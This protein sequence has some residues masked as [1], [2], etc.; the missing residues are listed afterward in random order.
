MAGSDD[1][2]LCLIADARLDQRPALAREL[3]LSASGRR[4]TDPEL[5]LAAYRRWGVGCLEH[6]L[7]DFSFLLWDEPRGRLFCARDHLG[8]RPLYYART[9]AGF[10]FGSSPDLLHTAGV[11]APELNR[12]R[13]ADYLA[14]GL[15]GISLTSSFFQSV[16]RLPPAHQLC[17]EADETKVA[18]YWNPQE[19][20]ELR[21]SSDAEAADAVMEVLGSAVS[22]RLSSVDN[23]ASMLSGGLDSSLL[24]C[25]T[26][27]LSAGA[28]ARQLTTISAL[29]PEPGDCPDPFYVDLVRRALDSRHLSVSTSDMAKL[30][31]ELRSFSVAA[32][33]PFDASMTMVAA[34]CLKAKSAGFEAVM[35]GVDGDLVAS[36]GDDYL[37]RLL[38]DGRWRTL[39][40][41][42]MAM[43]RIW[44][45]EVNLFGLFRYTLLPGLVPTAFRALRR[46]S[47]PSRIAT[48]LCRDT[49]LSKSFINEV[50]LV[51]RIGEQQRLGPS[52]VPKTMAEAHLRRVT[53][54][55]LT[56]GIERYSRVAD[57]CG[58]SHLSPLLDKRFVEFCVN[59]PW[60]FKVRHGQSKYLFRQLLKDQGLPQLSQRHD[61]YGLGRV[62]TRN[63]MLLN[64]GDDE[65]LLLQ[66][67]DRLAEFL[68]MDAYRRSRARYFE[69]GKM[70]DYGMWQVIHL[71]RWLTVR[72]L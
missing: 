43:G 9:A 12:Q 63:W 54:P 25:V 27:S 18:C 8:L 68:D 71:L 6:L 14:P 53:Q 49:L 60:N 3:N 21:F 51:E 13:V 37:Q 15:E 32:G 38:F 58:V 64:R 40:H 42:F 29:S 33:E 20:S 72:N 11:I 34:I 70:D 65:R 35:D 5:I 2:S 28:Q 47:A 55:G 46:R 4:F 23:V 66:H 69:E 48:R 39:A 7:G 61:K 59:L 36:L 17:V 1:R 16:V 52:G 22:D 57:A 56:V 50:G 45:E 10:V 30:L 31:G 19:R 44:R 67:E 41:E 26:R 24:A 62:F